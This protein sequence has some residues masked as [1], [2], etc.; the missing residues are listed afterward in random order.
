MTGASRKRK[1][2]RLRGPPNSPQPDRPPANSQSR[3]KSRSPSA[4][5]SHACT[6]QSDASLAAKSGLVP[7]SSREP[8]LFLIASALARTI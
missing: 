4:D 3:S 8:G 6:I 2:S 7:F 1:N 5:D